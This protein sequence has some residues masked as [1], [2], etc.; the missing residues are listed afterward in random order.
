M[1]TGFKLNS[2]FIQELKYILLNMK[3]SL[4]ESPLVWKYQL[5]KLEYVFPHMWTWSEN[6]QQRLRQ[7][8]GGL[9]QAYSR[10]TTL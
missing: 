10:I 3:Y 2:R 7:H 1:V 9:P 6:S 4:L 5:G 8:W